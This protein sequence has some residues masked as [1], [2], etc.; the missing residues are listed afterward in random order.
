M[1]DI[2]NILSKYKSI[3]MIGVSNDPTKAST[4]V[5]KYMQKY[6]FKVYPVNPSAKGQKILGEEVFSK[7]TD[8]KKQIDIV[9]VFRPSKEAIDIAKDTVNI[10][11]KVLWLQLGIKSDEAK[12][13]VE[14][15]KIKY[16]EDRCTKMEYQKHFLKVRQAFPVLQNQN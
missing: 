4:I 7:I 3:A 14:E 9:D 13:I 16:V 5:M 12:K 2:K 8:I 10:G 1:S 6:G 11:A 15:N